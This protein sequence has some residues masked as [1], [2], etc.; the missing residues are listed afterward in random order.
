MKVLPAS[1]IVAVGAPSST[2]CESSLASYNF[3]YA[4]PH[5]RTR[6]AAEE[7]EQQNEV[8]ILGGEQEEPW[9]VD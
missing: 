1:S 3:H 4:Y 2:V 9:K 5:A 7:E 8:D 6:G